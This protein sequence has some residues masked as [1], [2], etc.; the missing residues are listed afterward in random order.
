M[1]HDV[2]KWMVV[3]NAGKSCILEKQSLC[4]VRSST[5]FFPQS[6][7][8]FPLFLPP[9]TDLLAGQHISKSANYAVFATSTYMIQPCDMTQHQV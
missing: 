8:F 7:F 9:L 6:K 3:S 4:V 1:F 2:G 5:Q